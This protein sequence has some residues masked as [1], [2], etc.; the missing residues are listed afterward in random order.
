[1]GGRETGNYGDRLHGLVHCGCRPFLQ[2]STEPLLRAKLCSMHW[3]Q[4]LKAEAQATSM[5]VAQEG[6]WET[7]QQGQVWMY[8]GC[9]R[10]DR[11]LSLVHQERGLTF[12]GRHF[13]EFGYRA[14]S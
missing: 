2:M 6:T 14:P 1:M 9:A 4:R 10:S 8:S 12:T 11:P 3:W 7:I 13:Q 5:G